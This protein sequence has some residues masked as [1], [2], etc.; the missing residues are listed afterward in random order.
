MLRYKPPDVSK[1]HNT[2]YMD[3]NLLPNLAKRPELSHSAE[4]VIFL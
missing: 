1:I 2:Q 4:G 3:S